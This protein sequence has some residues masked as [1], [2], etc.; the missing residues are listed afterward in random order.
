MRE[1][2]RLNESMSLNRPAW[3]S[4]WRTGLLQAFRHLHISRKDTPVV[5][6]YFDKTRGFMK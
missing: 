4:E 2:I 1:Q 6:N 3:T 5:K